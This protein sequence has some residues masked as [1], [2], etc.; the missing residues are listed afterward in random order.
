MRRCFSKT[1]KIGSGV[2][3][4]MRKIRGTIEEANGISAWPK[5]FFEARRTRRDHRNA[6]AQRLGRSNAVTLERRRHDEHI[7]IR[8]LSRESVF[9]NLA[10]E[11]DVL[12][13]RA[14]LDIYQTH[15]RRFAIATARKTQLPLRLGDGVE[16]VGEI[17][18]A[19]SLDDRSDEEKDRLSR[20]VMIGRKRSRMKRQ[21]IR[22]G[23]DDIDSSAM[24]FTHE[25]IARRLTRRD[26]A[27]GVTKCSGLG[28]S[29]MRARGWAKL[30]F[31]TREV[32]NEENAMRERNTW[33]RE[34]DLAK[35]QLVTND[36]GWRET[37]KPTN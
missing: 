19:L 13:M 36:D 12:I 30:L 29:C 1:R 37:T 10:E 22:A 14:D 3:H 11:R 5:R 25:T 7:G 9:S 27:I 33:P 28:A 16:C 8:K 24:S 17:P 20:R 2:L 31:P 34:R 35:A 18:N 26:H 21:P 15:I 6:R 23:Q 4:R 32:M